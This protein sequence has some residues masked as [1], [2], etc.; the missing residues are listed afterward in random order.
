MQFWVVEVYLSFQNDLK[1]IL[2]WSNIIAFCNACFTMCKCVWSCDRNGCP[3]RVGGVE[4]FC[5]NY[6]GGLWGPSKSASAV[7]NLPPRFSKRYSWESLLFLSFNDLFCDEL[8]WNYWRRY[9]RSWHCELATII[10]IV[11]IFRVQFV[12][13]FLEIVAEMFR[14]PASNPKKGKAIKR[15][16][17][18]CMANQ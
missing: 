7:S 12:W 9:A 13:D 11:V 2:I 16:Q 1:N 14:L 5:V 3:N 18:K 6:T 8:S 15:N 10:K 17:I 4:V